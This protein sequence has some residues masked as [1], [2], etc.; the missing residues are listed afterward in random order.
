MGPGRQVAAQIAPRRHL[1]RVALAVAAIAVMLSLAGPA[2]AHRH[3][4]PVP[5]CGWAR[6]SLIART[7]GI[8]VGAAKSHWRVNIAPVLTCSYYEVTPSLAPI[9]EP[10]LTIAYAEVQRFKVPSTF[11]FVPHLGSCVERSSCPRPHKAGWL[12]TQSTNTNS[13]F[14]NPYTSIMQ[15]RVEDGLNALAMQVFT[16]NGP[17][18]VPSERA[19][20]LKLARKLLPRFYWR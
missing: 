5:S 15:L 12:Y 6:A 4:R 20:V 3:H 11:T 17:L 16:P 19:A 9:G 18:P 1:R 13:A 14:S 10:I 8:N 2:G 7:L